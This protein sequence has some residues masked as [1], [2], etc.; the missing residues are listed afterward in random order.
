M[1]SGILKKKPNLNKNDVETSQSLD[2]E[3]FNPK[4]NNHIVT[5]ESWDCISTN[6]QNRIRKALKALTN[7]DPIPIWRQIDNA[8]VIGY[9]TNKKDFNLSMRL[10]KFVIGESQ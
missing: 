1:R 5:P 3:E 6:A 4:N 7:G 2:D 10:R 8:I 9:P